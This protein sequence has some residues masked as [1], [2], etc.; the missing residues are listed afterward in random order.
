MVL[1]VAVSPATLADGLDLSLSPASVPVQPG[2]A[3]TT[4]MA[5][6]AAGPASA[7]AWSAHV[8][9]V[10]AM[11]PSWSSPL[12]TGTGL[13]EQRLRFD[14]QQQNAGNGANTTIVDSGKGVDLIVSDSNEIQIGAIPYSL[15]S[16][17]NGPSGAGG[18]SSAAGF[19]DWGFLRVKQRLAS[20]PAGAGNYI[21]T[22]QVQVQ[23]PAGAKPFTN[24]AWVWTP[25]L[26]A[27]KG[28]GDF[29]IQGTVGG[30]IPAPR[31]GVIG[32]QVQTNVALQYR[33]R[34]IFWPQLEINWTYYANGRRGGL[35]QVFLTPG[36]VLGRF[37]LS[38]QVKVSM[39]LGY[40]AAV[41]PAYRPTPL[42]PAYNHAWILSTRMNF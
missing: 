33:I 38:D 25:T 10:R 42:T 13:L 26:A 20:A 15:R 32:Y 37:S 8:A 39:G 19:N 1:G 3:D 40:Q 22:A 14:L 11:Q 24:N 7:S 21:L 36:L 29:D 9:R 12:V 2:G 23:A 27:G 34:R 6:P 16:G 35:N 5:D 41:T 31:A 30:F 18:V 4:I 17:A 28:W